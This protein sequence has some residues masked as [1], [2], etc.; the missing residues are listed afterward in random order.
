MPTVKDVSIDGLISH[1]RLYSVD[2][3]GLRSQ[4]MEIRNEVT[5]V[6]TLG[7]GRFLK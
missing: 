6:H 5:L 2:S 1:L 3:R 4:S 7:I